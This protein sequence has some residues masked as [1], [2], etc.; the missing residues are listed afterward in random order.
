[1]LEDYSSG[2]FR[3]TDFN[4]DMYEDVYRGHMKFLAH[5]REGSAV[6]YHRLMAG[7]FEEAS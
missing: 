7:L 4:A 5:I 3:K 2:T 6:K 1:M